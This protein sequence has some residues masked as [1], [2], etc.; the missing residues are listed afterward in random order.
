M[1]GVGILDG[2]HDTENSSK[3]ANTG[4]VCPGVGSMGITMR[5]EG[6]RKEGWNLIVSFQSRL[7]FLDLGGGSWA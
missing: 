5:M 3:A 7:W 4:K 2:A 1:A 6:V